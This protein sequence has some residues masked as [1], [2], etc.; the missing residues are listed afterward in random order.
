MMSLKLTDML[1]AVYT[2]KLLLI[3]AYFS[4]DFDV[5]RNWLAVT[6]SLPLSQWYTDD[7][8]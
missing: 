4:T 5:H 3:P 2:L 6:N 1:V 8:S 7:T